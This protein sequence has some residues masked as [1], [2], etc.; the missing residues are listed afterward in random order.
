MCIF[1]KI[2]EIFVFC[3]LGTIKLYRL[4]IGKPESCFSIPEEDLKYQNLS[5]DHV[6]YR[7]MKNIQSSMLTSKVIKSGLSFSGSLIR[8][9]TQLLTY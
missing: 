1:L 2:D 9:S 5:C 8:N 7:I 4:A 3:T 6:E